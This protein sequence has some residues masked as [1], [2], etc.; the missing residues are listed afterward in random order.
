MKYIDYLIDNQDS[1]GRQVFGWIEKDGNYALGATSASER[2][3]VGD[4]VDTNVQITVNPCFTC[5][6]DVNSQLTCEAIEVTWTD[7]DDPCRTYSCSD[8]GVPIATDLRESCQCA[9]DEE[10]VLDY[11]ITEGDQCCTCREKPPATGPTPP[12]TPAATPASRAPPPTTLAPPPTSTEP[13]IPPGPCQLRQ[14]TRTFS[15]NTSRGY[16]QTD[17]EIVLTTCSGTC[18]GYDGIHFSYYSEGETMIQKTELHHH[19]CTCCTGVGKWRR[20][21]VL[22]DHPGPPEVVELYEYT[23][24][25]CNACVP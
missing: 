11:D 14:R 6:C 9:D 21:K 13:Q 8:S 2:V 23:S 20:V 4:T 16:C 25:A 22:C 5:E 10:L 19:E 7:P 18:K 24:C 12:S 1:T 17:G 3:Y 15:F